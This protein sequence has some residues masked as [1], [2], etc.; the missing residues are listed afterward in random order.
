MPNKPTGRRNWLWCRRRPT[1]IPI[2][3]AYFRHSAVDGGIEAGNLDM[4]NLVRR[5]N[6]AGA[7]T[8]WLNRPEKLN[9][10]NKDVFEALDEHVE[11]LARETKTIGLVIL[12][13]AGANFSAGY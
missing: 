11:A 7:A 9:A 3:R 10:L 1:A 13:G 2:R 6:N 5:E 8:L 4:N 12:R